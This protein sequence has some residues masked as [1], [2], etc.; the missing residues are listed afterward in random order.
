MKL[1]TQK[2]SKHCKTTWSQLKILTHP[3]SGFGL[4]LYRLVN[5]I[6]FSKDFI[7]KIE[8]TVFYDDDWL[9]SKPKVIS[10][11]NNF[12]SLRFRIVLLTDFEK[13]GAIRG[14][15]KNYQ[16][17]YQNPIFDQTDDDPDFINHQIYES[18]EGIWYKRNQF[19]IAV[20]KNYSIEKNIEESK[21]AIQ[22]QINLWRSAKSTMKKF[23]LTKGE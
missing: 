16:P 9:I 21:K 12:L 23:R 19:W 4:N 3:I 8:K 15:T 14:W 10:V 22:N 5:K 17:Q 6:D 13:I 1:I 18:I 2:L 7:N 11:K 20:S